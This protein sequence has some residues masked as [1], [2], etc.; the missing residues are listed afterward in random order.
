MYFTFRVNSKNSLRIINLTLNHYNMA[1]IVQNCLHG[2]LNKWN[3][4]GKFI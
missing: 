4:L 2:A 3:R 1:Q